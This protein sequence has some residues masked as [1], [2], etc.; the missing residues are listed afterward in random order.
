MA[1]ITL[2]TDQK[3][4]NPEEKLLFIN[5]WNEWAEGAYL[6]PDEKYGYQ[7]LNIVRKIKQAETDEVKNLCFSEICK[8]KMANVLKLHHKDYKLFSCIPFLSYDEEKSLKKYYIFSKILLLKIK[9][10]KNYKIYILFG[11]I[12][13]LKEIC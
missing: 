3:F 4:D 6:E 10:K 13:I 2:Y 5:A 11:L 12:P 9:R 7:N 8:Q 1:E